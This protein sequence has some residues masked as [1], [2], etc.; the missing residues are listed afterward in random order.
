MSGKTVY[1]LHW[2]QKQRNAHQ[3]DDLIFAPEG[4]VE[5]ACKLLDIA[6]DHGVLPEEHR[7]C[8]HDDVDRLKELDVGPFVL[9]LLRSDEWYVAEVQEIFEPD[10]DGRL[11][12]FL[13][14]RLA[15]NVEDRIVRL[16]ELRYAGQET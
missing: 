5:A 15:P 6:E 11:C 13:D 12:F 16:V 9:R 14:N 4:Y 10:D 3:A 8:T 2:H 7:C 1:A